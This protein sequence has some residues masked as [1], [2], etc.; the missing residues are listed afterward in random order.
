MKHTLYTKSYLLRASPALGIDLSEGGITYAALK[1]TPLGLVLRTHG[2]AEL[3]YSAYNN[4]AFHDKTKVEGA[5]RL[6]KKQS[7]MRYVRATIP[8]EQVYVLDMTLPKIEKRKVIQKIKTHLGEL[9]PAFFNEMLISYEILSQ[10]KETFHLNVSVAKKAFVDEY[11]TLLKK[12]GFSVVS[13][14]FRS[15]AIAD[16]VIPRTSHE[17]CLVA[18]LDQGKLSVFGVTDGFIVAGYTSGIDSPSNFLAIKEKIDRAYIEWH[19]ATP[20]QTIKTIVLAGALGATPGLVDYLSVSLKMRVVL[21]DVWTNVNTFDK[22]IPELTL[23]HSLGYAPAIG[24][25]LADF[26]K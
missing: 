10:D 26:E 6:I 1:R 14:E 23:G 20:A 21:A 17:P 15:A 18:V 9:L 4:G 5:L 22:Y 24:L 8:E 16:A 3:P 25:A 11:L 7:R 13:L 2:R 19:K 12:A